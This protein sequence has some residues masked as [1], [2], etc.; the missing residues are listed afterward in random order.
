MPDFSYEGEFPDRELGEAF[1]SASQ[2]KRNVNAGLFPSQP[3]EAW[4]G[5]DPN[6]S[7]LSPRQQA[8]DYFVARGVVVSQ[9]ADAQR[10]RVP[11]TGDFIPAHVARDISL[12]VRTQLGTTAL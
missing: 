12:D 7:P 3:G 4:N 8:R 10:W 1:R 9:T 11:G 6:E 5:T 2:T